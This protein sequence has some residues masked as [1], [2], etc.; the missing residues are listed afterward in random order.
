MSSPATFAG[1]NLTICGAPCSNSFLSGL[2][3]MTSMS[4]D[5]GQNWS[6]RCSY[7]SAFGMQLTTVSSHF[8]WKVII[9]GNEKSIPTT[10]WKRR[11]VGREGRDLKQPTL[12]LSTVATHPKK[13]GPWLLCLL[14]V[15]E[16]CRGGISPYRFKKKK[17]SF[18]T[19]LSLLWFSTNSLCFVSIMEFPVWVCDYLGRFFLGGL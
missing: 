3:L 15:F 10:T 14:N 13:T 16:K 12:W 2:V 4:P 6:L 17:M 5:T 18:C 8:L 11:R 1:Q 7:C 19:R 9:I